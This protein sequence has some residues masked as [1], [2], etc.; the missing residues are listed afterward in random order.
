MFKA[1]YTSE[2]YR[3]VREALNAE[4]DSWHK[5][6]D[7]L[8]PARSVGDL[9]NVVY[10]LEPLCRE[11]E[12]LTALEGTVLDSHKLVGVIGSSGGAGQ[13]PST[14]FDGRY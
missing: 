4:V 9:W 3:A 2:F 14:T 12:T 8:T 10:D 1:A 13:E 6:E 11:E 7:A 5:H